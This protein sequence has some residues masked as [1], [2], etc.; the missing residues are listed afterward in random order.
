MELRTVVKLYPFCFLSFQREKQI[1]ECG[2][3]K[4]VPLLSSACVRGNSGLNMFIA[5]IA[6]EHRS[7]QMGAFSCEG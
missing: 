3:K 6:E 4:I 2:E 7:L 1:K 5:G